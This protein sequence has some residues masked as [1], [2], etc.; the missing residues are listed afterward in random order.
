MK[1]QK[2]IVVPP[3]LTKDKKKDSQHVKDIET[4]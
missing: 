3:L 2:Y 4:R 1:V